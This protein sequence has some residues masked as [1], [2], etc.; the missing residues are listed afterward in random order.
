M[1]LIGSFVGFIFGLSLGLIALASAQT[2][3]PGTAPSPCETQ[4]QIV[5]FSRKQV[6]VQAA[7]KISELQGEIAK[8]QK[9]AGQPK[10]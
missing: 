4:I 10:K 8:L 5:E 7:Q 9:Q 2:S 6:E 3:M 1:S